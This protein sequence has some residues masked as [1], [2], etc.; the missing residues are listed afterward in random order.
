MT[1]IGEAVLA[2]ALLTLAFEVW[3]TEDVAS[4]IQLYTAAAVGGLLVVVLARWRES[5][6]DDDM[7]PAL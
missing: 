3:M 6:K 4:G 7:P 1:Q 5:R 2:G